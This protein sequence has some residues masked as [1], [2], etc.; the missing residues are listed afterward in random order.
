MSSTTVGHI[1]EPHRRAVAIGDDQRRVIGARKQ[2]IVGADLIRLM[3]AV[4]IALG[5]IHVGGRD[6]VAQIFQV[7]SVR[8]QRR[9]VGLDAHRRLLAAADAHQSHA[10]QLRNLG[11]QPRIG[12]ILHLR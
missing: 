8:R 12:Q 11:R 3:R 4:E 5:L 1:G 9:R 2:L 6:G 10:R 7:Q